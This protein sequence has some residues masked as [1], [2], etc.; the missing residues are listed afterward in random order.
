MNGTAGQSIYNELNLQI[1]KLCLLVYN[2]T[3]LLVSQHN[4][5][6]TLSALSNKTGGDELWLWIRRLFLLSVGT[7]MPQVSFQHTLPKPPAA[8]C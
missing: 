3:L 2:S 4:K 6:L 8:A 5:I 1:H 7:G